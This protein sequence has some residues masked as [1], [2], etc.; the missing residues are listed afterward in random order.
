[1]RFTPEE[2]LQIQQV[3][4]D[5]STTK[6]AMDALAVTVPKLTSK[7]KK[8]PGY[9]SYWTLRNWLQNPSSFEKDFHRSESPSA[10]PSGTKPASGHRTSISLN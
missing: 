2:R 10:R 9:V 6:E 4:Q 5:C 1:M 3:L 7:D 8:A